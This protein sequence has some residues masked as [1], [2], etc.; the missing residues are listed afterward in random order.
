MRRARAAA[1]LLLRRRGWLVRSVRR[2]QSRRPAGRPSSVFGSNASGTFLGSLSAHDE[3]RRPAGWRRARATD[4]RAPRRGDPEF[5]APPATSIGAA[6]GSSTA[7]FGPSGI[8]DRCLS[9]GSAGAKTSDGFPRQAEP[10]IDDHPLA[11]RQVERLEEFVQPRR[12]AIAQQQQERL[13]SIRERP[14]LQ[15]LVRLERALGPDDDQQGEVRR[16]VVGE[17]VEVDDLAA[18]LVETAPSSCRSLG[19]A[20]SSP[21]STA[22]RARP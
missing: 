14:E 12:L 15:D 20:D 17:Q 11:D 19:P 8:D 13:P 10:R 22:L 1:C 18:D 3:L 5:P 2:P 7:R 16:D 9:A 4:R 6:P 21:P